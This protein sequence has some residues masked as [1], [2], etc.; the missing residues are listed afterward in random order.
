MPNL[1]DNPYA[2]M[3][4]G[5]LSANVRSPQRQNP[6]DHMLKY[7]QVSQQRQQQELQQKYLQMQLQQMRQ[8]QAQAEQ[9]RMQQERQRMIDMRRQK[10]LRAYGQNPTAA[11][12]AALFPEEYA[13][14][15]IKNEFEV[16]EDG[17]FKG[18]S[19]EVQALNRYLLQF[20]PEQ[21]EDKANKLA[22]QRLQRDIT[23]VTP[24]G[25]YIR[26][27]Y[28]LGAVGAPQGAPQ[29]GGQAGQGTLIPKQPSERE[30][31][32]G[33]VAGN[34]ANLENRVRSVLDSEDF[35][36]SS[37]KH[38]AGQLPGGNFMVSGDF[39]MYRSAADEWATNMVFLRSGATARQ[40]EKDTSFSNFWTQPGDKEETKLF[41]EK[42]RL[43]VSIEALQFATRDGRIEKP[44]ADEQ[45]AAL[46]K[47]LTEL[48]SKGVSVGT[49]LTS[50]QKTLFEKYGIA[51]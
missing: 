4:M 2:Q 47:R 37:A 51:E 17:L 46:Q 43:E 20:P 7:Q 18:K 10:E 13:K 30:R 28:D 50:E 40:E 31:T 1:L 22:E 21:R 39:Q 5:L 38:M 12:A 9:Q 41:K 6:Y 44:E 16:G 35:D 23:T 36:P 32:A 49:E 33:F 24:E 11:G 29:A 14:E 3:G 45:I 19:V 42:M 26:P 34:L 15:Q 8:Q 48:E 25:T 27:G